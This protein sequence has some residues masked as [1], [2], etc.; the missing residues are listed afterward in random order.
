MHEIN[1]LFL[2]KN[3]WYINNNKCA[4]RECFLRVLENYPNKQYY[5]YNYE[6]KQ[7]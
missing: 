7:S 6:L 3:L 1:S 4:Y 2:P 5:N